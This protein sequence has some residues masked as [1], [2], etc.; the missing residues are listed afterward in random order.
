MN[1]IGNS[2][3]YIGRF[4][5][6]PELKKAKETSVC[7]FTLARTK[8]VPN[9]K[10]MESDYINFVAW[11]KMAET[12][13]K[14]FKKGNKIGVNG[15]LY[16]HKYQNKSGVNITAVE[17][18]VDNIEFVDGSNKQTTSKQETPEE[19]SAPVNG[20]VEEESEDESENLPF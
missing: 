20:A 3:T 1:K 18:H 15:F 7:N 13:C 8:D 10:D 16:T 6:D 17:V 11:G 14:Y 9:G 4:V 12:I 5:S 2:V 19:N